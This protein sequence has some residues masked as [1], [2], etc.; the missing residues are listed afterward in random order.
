MEVLIV[1]ANVSI[2]LFAGFVWVWSGI[3]LSRYVKEGKSALVG[4]TWFWIFNPEWFTEEGQATFRKERMRF[5]SAMLLV[6]ILGLGR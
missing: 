2:S 3:T 5:V 6:T 1:I 4:F